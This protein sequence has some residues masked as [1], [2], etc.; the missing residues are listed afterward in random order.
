M[1]KSFAPVSVVAPESVTPFPVRP[2]PPE[3]AMSPLEVP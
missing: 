3:G 1:N 2:H